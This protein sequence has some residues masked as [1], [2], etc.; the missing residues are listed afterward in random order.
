MTTSDEIEEIFKVPAETNTDWDGIIK[1][2]DKILSRPS[3]EKLISTYLDRKYGTSDKE[4]K[5]EKDKDIYDVPEEDVEIVKKQTKKG[6]KGKLNMGEYMYVQTIDFLKT[7]KSVDPTM[8]VTD[9]SKKLP[10]MKDTFVLKINEDL[11]KK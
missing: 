1:S 6:K 4:Q 7:L 2:I 8:T 3:V 11:E 5:E 9:L 10:L